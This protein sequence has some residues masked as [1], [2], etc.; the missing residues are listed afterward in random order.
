M[1]ERTKKIFGLT[2]VVFFG[3]CI[4]LGFVSLLTYI[5]YFATFNRI[6]NEFIYW[7]VF[8]VTFIL[9]FGFKI[10]SKKIV[11]SIFPLILLGGIFDIFYLWQISEFILRIA[12]TLWIVFV[13]KLFSERIRKKEVN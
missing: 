12:F 7:I 2:I 9:A 5:S 10:Q 13:I 6:L 8:F 4:Y 1:K 3:V 11:L